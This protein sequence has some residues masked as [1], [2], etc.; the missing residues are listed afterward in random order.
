MKI[1]ILKSCSGYNFSFRQSD[2]VDVEKYIG[3]DLVKCGFA[4]EVKC[5]KNTKRDAKNTAEKTDVSGD[6]NAGT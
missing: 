1:K 6:N 2:V 3:E 5:V 4:E